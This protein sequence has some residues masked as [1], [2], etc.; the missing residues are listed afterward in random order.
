[1]TMWFDETTEEL[2]QNRA[3]LHVTLEDDEMRLDLSDRHIREEFLKVAE[4]VDEYHGA[5]DEE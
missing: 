3:D 2:V 1:M 5:T 4:Q